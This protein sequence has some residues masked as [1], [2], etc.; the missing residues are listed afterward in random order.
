MNLLRDGSAKL[1]HGARIRATGLFISSCS[2][3][4]KAGTGTVC[5]TGC[6]LEAV[7]AQARTSMSGVAS[8]RQNCDIAAALV[9]HRAR[10]TCAQFAAWAATILLNET[11][12]RIGR[13]GAQD[14]SC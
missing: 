10:I 2:S 6:P 14:H 9:A 1:G 3:P 5:K 8:P 12:D 7:P 11:V 13:D 4:A